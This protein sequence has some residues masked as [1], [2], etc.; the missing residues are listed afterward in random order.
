MEKGLYAKAIEWLEKNDPT[1][2]SDWYYNETL[3]GKYDKIHANIGLYAAE[4]KSLEYLRKNYPSLG[5]FFDNNPI[6]KLYKELDKEWSLGVDVIISDLKSLFLGEE[7]PN[8]TNLITH[9]Q[10]QQ[11]PKR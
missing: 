7:S 6:G 3:L 9:P 8:T 4:K 10:S 11:A 2:F 5:G 1:G